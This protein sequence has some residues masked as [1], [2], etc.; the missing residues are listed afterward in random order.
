VPHHHRQ[1][2]TLPAERHKPLSYAG[3]VAQHV[4]DRHVPARPA[5]AHQEQARPDTHLAGA[6]RAGTTVVNSVTWR[7][8]APG[9]TTKFLEVSSMAQNIFERIILLPLDRLAYYSYKLF[10]SMFPYMGRKW[11]QSMAAPVVDEMPANRH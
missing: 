2:L 5:K 8:I 10:K 3:V 4:Y 7:A 9:V 11:R 1:F 6:A